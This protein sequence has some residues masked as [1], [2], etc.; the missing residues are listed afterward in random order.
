MTKRPADSRFPAASNYMQAQTHPH[1]IFVKIGGKLT[2]C[3]LSENDEIVRLKDLF[4]SDQPFWCKLG[5][6]DEDFAA[7]FS[8]KHQIQLPDSSMRAGDTAICLAPLTEKFLWH[9]PETLDNL[10]NIGGESDVS[11][12]IKWSFVVCGREICWQ[13]A[14]QKSDGL[15][16]T[17]L[18]MY[19]PQISPQWKI[20]AD[21]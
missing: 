5:K 4:L 3:D 21:L 11:A 12:N 20:Y 1:Q 18:A 13:T 2:A 16:N 9:F 17:S 7:R 19:P 14:A 15:T 6:T 8:A 10:E